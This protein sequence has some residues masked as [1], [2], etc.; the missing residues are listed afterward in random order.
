MASAQTEWVEHPD[1]PVIGLGEPG[2]WDDDMRAVLAVHFDGSVYHLWFMGDNVA[3]EY[4]DIGHATS[5]DGV[6]WTMDPANPVLTRGEPGEWDDGL[7]FGAGVV[8]DGTQYHLWYS[9]V[10]AQTGTYQG[11]YATSPDG[12][13]WTKHPDNPVL[14]PGPAG[15]WD[16]GG[17]DPHTVIL[18]D[19]VFRMWYTAGTAY[20]LLQT[21]YAESTDGVHWTKHPDNPV[22]A[23]GRHPGAWDSVYVENAY[24][25]FDGTTYHMWYT[26]W[27]GN[28][29]GGIGYAVSGD[30]I[31]WMK[32]GD[33]WVFRSSEGV[34]SNTPVY[35]DGS[36]FHM[37]YTQAP[38]TA[39]P[40]RIGYATSDCCE[41]DPA[42]DDWLFIPAAALASG[43]EGAFY[44]TDVD[45]NNAGDQ[46]VEYQFL[47][48]P[49]GE[50]N[51]DP[52][53]SEAFNLGAGM[54]VRYANVLSE[55]FGLEP[56]S[57]GALIVRSSSPDL[58][59][60]SRTYNNPEGEDA[61]T[62]GQAIPAVPLSDFIQ[63]GERRR[64]LFASEHEDLRFNVGCQNGG[65]S[66]AVVNLELFDHEGA[67]L[68]QT[69]MI[70]RALGNDQMNRLLQDYMPVNGYVDVYGSG[71]FYCYGSVLD[72]VTSDPTTVL[73]Q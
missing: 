27:D 57:L 60:M 23:A 64:I 9:G 18:E 52:M 8:H 65:E 5:P 55:V 66:A 41:V 54:S 37:W 45:L 31:E 22:V 59:A 68:D 20:V 28:E 69:I 17:V 62:F 32:H 56:N 19:G 25:A 34:T 26:G 30:G 71:S 11:G 61:G 46:S 40:L 67:L 58:L 36:T 50:T 6:D 1:N 72:N 2:E 29:I 10:G 38:S 51:T 63:T 21:G 33:S 43:A 48:L 53:T 47:W 70:L 13:V 16:D 3:G 12:T 14:K 15:A 4:R 49:R 39:G 42:L 73:P 35:F 44:Q 24:V 7:L